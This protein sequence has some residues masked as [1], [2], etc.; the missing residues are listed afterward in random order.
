MNGNI[1]DRCT[2]ATNL[3]QH[4]TESF[5]VNVVFMKTTCTVFY[6]P[7]MDDMAIMNENRQLGN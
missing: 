7:G 4:C 2:K 3:L 6:E 5:H 1:T